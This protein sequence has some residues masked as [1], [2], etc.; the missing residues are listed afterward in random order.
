MKTKCLTIKN[1]KSNLKASLCSVSCSFEELIAEKVLFSEKMYE[2]ED[3]KNQ[4]KCVWKANETWGWSN[5]SKN[6]SRLNDA[7]MENEISRIKSANFAMSAG[8]STTWRRKERMLEEK[9]RSKTAV[10]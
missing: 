8:N 1:E 10:G 2:Y 7:D 6:T 5:T 9:G 3:C 4:K